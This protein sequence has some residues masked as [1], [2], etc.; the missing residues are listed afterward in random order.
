VTDSVRDRI[1]KLRKQ[2]SREQIHV[3]AFF[4]TKVRDEPPFFLAASWPVD[5]DDPAGFLD[6]DLFYAVVYGETP[7]EAVSL[8]RDKLYDGL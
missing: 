1:A 6:P 5:P 2:L 8:F 4:G 7:E 3:T